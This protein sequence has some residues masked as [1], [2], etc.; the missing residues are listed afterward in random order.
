MMD[1]RLD[2]CD[3]EILLRVE[4]LRHPE[5]KI[6]SCEQSGASATVLLI[7]SSQIAQAKAFEEIGLAGGIG[8]SLT[9]EQRSGIWQ[10]VSEGF[11]IG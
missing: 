10:V 3:P 2:R 11:W 9:F 1:E 8:R 6:W 4:E 7:E 5:E